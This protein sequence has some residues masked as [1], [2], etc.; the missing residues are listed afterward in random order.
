MRAEAAR[1][2]PC[3]L[4]WRR[5][6]LE[7]RISV[8]RRVVYV[9]FGICGVV[10]IAATG[11]WYGNPI[12]TFFHTTVLIAA[13]SWGIMGITGKDLVEWIETAVKKTLKKA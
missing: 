12:A 5:F 4:D 11:F 10:A 7:K 2:A 9:V 13:T 8:F 3:H 1:H 6:V